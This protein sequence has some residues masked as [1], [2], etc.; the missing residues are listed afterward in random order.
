MVKENGERKTS[1]KFVGRPTG[2]RPECVALDN[3]LNKDTDTSLALHVALTSELPKDDKRKFSMSTPN[4]IVRAIER[5]WHPEDGVCPKSQR[6]V[7]DLTRAN[8]AHLEIVKHD[9]GI[10]P[11]LA[12]RNGHR[13]TGG[14]GRRYTAPRRDNGNWVRTWEEMGIHEDAILAG[15]EYYESH[16]NRYCSI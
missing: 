2:N 16:K 10:V 4:E 11:G 13:N 8:Y 9:G 14:N 7:Q 12:N 1:R 15:K 5:L 6:I 3:S